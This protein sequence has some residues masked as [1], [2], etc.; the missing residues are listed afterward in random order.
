MLFTSRKL[1]VSPELQ[2][3]HVQEQ[4]LVVGALQGLV[5]V[6]AFPGR[7]VGPGVPQP[8]PA[9]QEQRGQQDRPRQAGGRQ[10]P[11]ARAASGRGGGQGRR[12]MGH[13]SGKAAARTRA[14]ALLIVV[15]RG[16]V[17]TGEG[18]GWRVTAMTRP[19]AGKSVAWP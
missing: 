15:A 8:G 5:V 17:A 19:P 9:R 12:G 18:F 3:G 7:T 2:A 14:A 4:L 16:G 13:C 1:G 6:E 10:A 11:W